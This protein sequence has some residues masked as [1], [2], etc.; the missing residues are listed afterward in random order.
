[1]KTLEYIFANALCFDLLNK[2]NCGAKI[3]KSTIEVMIEEYK[4]GNEQELRHNTQLSLEQKEKYKQ[5]YDNMADSIKECYLEHL[6][7]QSRLIE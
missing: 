1:M 7:M 5:L 4:K 3:Q 2:E 6:R